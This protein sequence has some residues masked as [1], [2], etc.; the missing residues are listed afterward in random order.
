MRLAIGRKLVVGVRHAMGA[1]KG[2]VFIVRVHRWGEIRRRRR[3]ERAVAL[4]RVALELL[5]LALELVTM[6]NG[7]NA[8]TT[9]CPVIVVETSHQTEE[10]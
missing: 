2:S 9:G 4:R 6:Q 10:E 3:L 8:I 7:G 5:H 1:R